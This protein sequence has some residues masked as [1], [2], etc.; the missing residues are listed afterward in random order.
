M[1]SYLLRFRGILTKDDFCYEPQVVLDGVCNYFEFFTKCWEFEFVNRHIGQYAERIYEYLFN[2]NV[3][4]GFYLE[5]VCVRV[6][7][8]DDDGCFIILRFDMSSFAVCPR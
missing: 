5:V 1:K 2:K 4:I 7:S 3:W 8:F 6:D